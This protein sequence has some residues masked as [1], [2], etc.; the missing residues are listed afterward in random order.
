[1]HSQQYC[2][3]WNNHSLNFISMFDHLLKTEAFTDV[4]LA[5]SDGATIKCHKVVLAACSTYF[6][7][8]FLKNPCD[9]PILILGDVQ[10]HEIKSILEYMY[11]G[12]VNVAHEHLHS[13]LRIATF[14]K[15]YNPS[16]ISKIPAMQSNSN[17][18]ILI[19]LLALAI[20]HDR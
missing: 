19:G 11:K 5:V 8:L 10:Y 18:H 15:V 16:L 6:Q 9:H 20:W 7:D 2:L 1:M 3:R 17:K 13:M 4:T 12:E 14:L